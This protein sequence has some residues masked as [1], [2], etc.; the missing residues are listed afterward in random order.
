MSTTDSIIDT[1]IW[2]D[3]VSSLDSLL[4][5]KLEERIEQENPQQRAVYAHGVA[6]GFISET[7]AESTIL[8]DVWSGNREN[9]LSRDICVIRF[10]TEDGEFLIVGDSP[11]GYYNYTEVRSR[12]DIDHHPFEWPV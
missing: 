1:E 9:S 5:E 12:N 7:F 10:T 8:D 11:V 2:L 3:Q 4:T 6:F